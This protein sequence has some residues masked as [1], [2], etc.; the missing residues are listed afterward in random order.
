MTVRDR[1]L[2]VGTNWLS[3][4]EDGGLTI[5]FPLTVEI[6]KAEANNQK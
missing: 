1:D 3:E 4:T 5:A 2:R 6:L